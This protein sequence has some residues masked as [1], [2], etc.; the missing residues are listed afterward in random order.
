MNKSEVAKY[1]ANVMAVSRSDGLLAPAEESALELVQSEIGAKKRDLKAAEKLLARADFASQPVGRLSDCVRNLEDMAFVAA[2]DGDVADAERE[3]LESFA[4]SAGVTPE[5]FGLI[6][7]NAQAR[8]SSAASAAKCPACQ[9]DIL[10]GS[11]FCPH[12]GSN[13]EDQAAPAGKK[14][15]FDYPSSGLSIEF[16]ESSSANFDAALNIASAAPAFQE[17]EKSGKSWY[18]ATW[19]KEQI[20]E[21]AALAEKLSGLRNRRAWLDGE[22]LEWGKAFGFLWCMKE[23]QS[24]YHP[25]EYCFGEGTDNLNVWGCRQARMDWSDWCDWFG[26]GEF[27]GK[28]A[29]VF[30][31]E[32]IGHELRQNTRSCCLCPFFRPALVDWVL[33]L[34][35]SEVRIGRRSGWDYKESYEETPASIRVT[36]KR[37][38]G[39]GYTDTD[40]IYTE[41]VKPVGYAVL[42]DI[43][44]K[45]FKSAGVTDVDLRR[46][47]PK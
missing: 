8:V 18:L 39:G 41:G 31:K 17:C 30:N 19:P 33:Q 7:Q 20:T 28:D 47:I 16:A 26:Y 6:M 10:Q 11:K 29:F 40:Q 32:R 24:A 4:G 21:A 3:M 38:Y 22:E 43:L 5:Q 46:L 15:E 25:A 23:R 27:R 37:D 1:L 2:A 45:A 14:L 9:R 34:L 44:A 13:L 35:P 36:V 12:C 42:K